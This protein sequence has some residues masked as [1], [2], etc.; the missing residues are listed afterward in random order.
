[1]ESIRKPIQL[2]CRKYGIFDSI[3][4]LARVMREIMPAKDFSRLSLASDV[5]TQPSKIPSTMTGLAKWL[6]EYYSK[7]EMALEL[8]AALEPR[9]IMLVLT[10]VVDK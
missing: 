5:Q 9:M 2:Q 3:G 7:L 10:V 1:M 8:G 4:I 6:E